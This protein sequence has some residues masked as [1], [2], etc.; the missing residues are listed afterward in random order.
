MQ[1]GGGIGCHSLRGKRTVA[2]ASL[3]I[4]SDDSSISQSAVILRGI[5]RHA[6]PLNT[7]QMPHAAASAF[8]LLPA[9]MSIQSVHEEVHWS[10]QQSAPHD[11]LI[12]GAMNR[13]VL[14]GS[15]AV[16]VSLQPPYGLLKGRTGQDSSSLSLFV[17]PSEAFILCFALRC[18]EVNGG[19]P[20]GWLD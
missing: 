12:Q 3:T 17:F 19:R 18:I 13:Q 8:R 7:L 2:V 4:I 15:S 10:V 9:T 5:S 20:F 16:E 1:R 14:H 11:I 6:T